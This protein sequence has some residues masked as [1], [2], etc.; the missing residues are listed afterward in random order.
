[1]IIDKRSLTTIAVLCISVLCAATIAML[2]A[3]IIAVLCA[4]TIAIIST[5]A[6][7]VAIYSA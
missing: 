3:A 7:K 2:F 6:Q 5:L 1:L 4:A